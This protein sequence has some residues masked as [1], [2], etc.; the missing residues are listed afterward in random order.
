MRG[1]GENPETVR[2]P[3]GHRDVEPWEPT[4]RE[5]KQ[6]LR[7][8]RWSELRLVRAARFPGAAGR[9]PNF[10]GAEAAAERLG[11]ERFW[12]RAQVLKCNPD[13]PQRPVRHLA[14]KEGKKIYLAAPRLRE[15]KPFLLLDPARIAERDWWKASSITGA[16]ELGRPVTVG[17]MVPVDLVI[18][19]SVAVAPDG[20]RLGKGGGYSDLEY[21]LLRA[22]GKISAR[23]PIATTVHPT[24]VLAAH[25]IPMDEHDVA[26][27]YFVTPA[28]V[29]HCERRYPR[30]KGVLWENLDEDMRL[31]IPVLGKGRMRQG[32][33]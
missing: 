28:Q 4:L 6:D 32:V 11:R 23:T 14:L 29:V 25:E 27:D 9:I 3:D 26:I 16:F 22:A 30:P 2:G 10:T 17:R 19:G 8:A 15:R 20:A 33:R 21:G 7:R 18:T 1:R 24:Q 31:S 13:L 12:R 5:I